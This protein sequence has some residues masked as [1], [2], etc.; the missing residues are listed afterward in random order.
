VNR[1]GL[2]VHRIIESFLFYSVAGDYYDF[3]LT[4]LFKA[5]GISD[6]VLANYA[7]GNVLHI[8]ENLKT[9]RPDLHPEV[10][11]PDEKQVVLD[12]LLG[13]E[14]DEQQVCL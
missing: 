14:S 10:G 8:S 2:C 12:Y 4:P 3:E 1:A 6:E 11:I 7:S 9:L 13:P 5:I